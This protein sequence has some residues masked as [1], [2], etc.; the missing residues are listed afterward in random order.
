MLP[1]ELA[2]PVAQQAQRREVIQLPC[3]GTTPDTAR[4]EG[5]HGARRTAVVISG[6]GRRPSLAPS[7]VYLHFVKETLREGMF[8]FATQI[9]SETRW[10]FELSVLPE[11][12]PCYD[13]CIP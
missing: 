2:H 4:E 11:K 6:D 3:Q 10:Q 5:Q 13:E 12:I 7:P 9:W 1:F 8:S